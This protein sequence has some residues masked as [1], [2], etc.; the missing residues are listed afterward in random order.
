MRKKRPDLNESLFYDKYFV[1]KKARVQ[2]LAQEALKQLAEEGA[3]RDGGSL[4]V[5]E[6][7][8][9]M[10]AIQGKQYFCLNL[11]EEASLKAMQTY[12]LSKYDRDVAEACIDY[13]T[14]KEVG[15]ELVF[16]G[17]CL[18]RAHVVDAWRHPDGGKVY[19]VR[20]KQGMN[21]TIPEAWVVK[22]LDDPTEQLN[23]NG[24]V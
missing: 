21:Y 17:K 10:C 9:R 3:G 11:D 2:M 1:I 14:K 24:G 5:T 4:D 23:E 18:T 19:E 12:Y 22:W 20:D 7:L 15:K 8:D 6:V 13:I 16:K